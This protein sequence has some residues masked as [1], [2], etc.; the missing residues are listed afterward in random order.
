MI[1]SILLWGSCGGPKK[2][3]HWMEWSKVIAPIFDGGLGIGS[4]LAQ[5]IALLIK[6]WRRMMNEKDSLWKMVI[7]SI[8]NLYNKLLTI[9]LRQMWHVGVFGSKS[10][11]TW[12][13]VQGF[14]V[15]LEP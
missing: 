13:V 6:W 9:Y 5:N 2:K 7:D 14:R 10:K 15:F 11:V 4:L 1:R 3:I 8:H 12:S